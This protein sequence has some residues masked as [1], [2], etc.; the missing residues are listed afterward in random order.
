[1]P[2]P[3]RADARWCSTRCR[4]AAHR[5]RRRPPAELIEGRRWV[6]HSARKVP[7]TVTGDAASSTNPATWATY[8]EACQSRVGVGLGCVLTGDGIVCIDLDHCL[9]PDGRPTA[10]AAELLAR[11]P[12]TWVEVSPSGD[13]L[14][15]WGRAEFA[16]GRKVARPG[17]RAEVYGSGRFITVTG[18][19]YEGAPAV[20]A[21][22]TDLVSLLT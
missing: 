2:L 5:S 10:W 15:V 9:D 13:G 6:R 3:V 8:A 1:M 21:D 12:A 16:G 11:I 18:R 19:P 22:I 14:H 4:V 7:L 20:L 17:W